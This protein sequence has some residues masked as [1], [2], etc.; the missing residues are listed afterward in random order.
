[1]MRTISDGVLVGA[2][3]PGAA[4][5]VLVTV[6]GLLFL[7]FPTGMS[8]YFVLTRPERFIDK[9]SVLRDFLRART[10]PGVTVDEVDGRSTSTACIGRGYESFSSVLG[11]EIDPSETA[12]PT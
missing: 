2:L 4:W 11:D 7:L 3:V 10:F 6:G 8:E 9:M 5:E 1:M 12:M